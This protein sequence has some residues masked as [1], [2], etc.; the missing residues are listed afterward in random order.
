MLSREQQPHPPS[1]DRERIIRA[2]LAAE[3][4]FKSNPSVRTPPEPET[5]PADQAARKPRALQIVSPPA[6]VR[7][8]DPERSVIS[9]PPARE[10]PRS[11][12]GRIRAWVKYGMTVAQVAQVYG[13]PVSEIERI[14]GKA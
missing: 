14:L 3:A 1:D 8:T 13:V 5:A 11:Q 6:S 4:L 9:P 2:R 12:C 7:R 10:I